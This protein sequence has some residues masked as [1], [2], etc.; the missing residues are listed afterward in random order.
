MTPI[1]SELARQ[2]LLIPNRMDIKIC[3]QRAKASFYIQAD[4]AHVNMGIKIDVQSAIMR[5]RKVKMDPE[6]LIAHE[7]ALSK[8]NATI[9]FEERNLTSLTVNQGVSCFSRDDLF[10]G[11]IPKRVVVGIVNS[12]ALA[13]SYVKSPYK[14]EHA[15]ISQIGFTVNG[16]SIPGRPI[17][18]LPNEPLASSYRDGYLSLLD[19]AGLTFKNSSLLFEADDWPSGYSFFAFSFEPDLGHAGCLSRRKQGLVGLDVRFSAGLTS[20]MELVIIYYRDS[21]LEIDSRRNAYLPY[22][23]T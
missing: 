1:P 12:Q 4:A 3:L 2:P 13:G 16:E 7:I 21:C 8:R 10:R 17:Q 23:R 9:Y 11:I 19:T 18:F 14:V 15:G 6:F 5:L 20:T 22:K